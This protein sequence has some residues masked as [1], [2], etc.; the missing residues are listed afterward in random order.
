MAYQNTVGAKL[1]YTH[2]DNM[3]FGVCVYAVSFTELIVLLDI[4][5]KKNNNN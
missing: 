4:L 3:Q 2:S 1:Y 5:C